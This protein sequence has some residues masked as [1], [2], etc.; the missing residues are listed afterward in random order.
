MTYRF[1]QFRSTIRFSSFATCFGYQFGSS[2]W[3][4]SGYHS[5]F[6]LFSRFG[7]S[8]ACLL[9][10]KYGS[11]CCVYVRRSFLSVPP[12]I[13]SPGLCPSS[14]SVSLPMTHLVSLTSSF[15]VGLFAP[16]A[17][18]LQL[19]GILRIQNLD[20]IGC[21][22][23]ISALVQVGCLQPIFSLYAL[24]DI[25]P[26]LCHGLLGLHPKAKFSIWFAF[27]DISIL[28]LVPQLVLTFSSPFIPFNRPPQVLAYRGAAHQA[29]PKTTAT[30]GDPMAWWRC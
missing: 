29:C 12:S 27:P 7:P 3:I 14:G 19:I 4:R 18:V 2:F 17:L 11:Y 24:H 9:K 21:L 20:W 30:C 16:L 28:R 10:L 26:C 8:W 13:F 1:T 22:R 23:F 6:G 5:G 25:G 15:K